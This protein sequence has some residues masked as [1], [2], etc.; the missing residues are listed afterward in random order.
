MC[1]TWGIPGP[2]PVAAGIL[3]S[4]ALTY[5]LLRQRG[6]AV[7]FSYVP[8]SMEDLE[9][10][11]D[12][13]VIVKPE[14]GSATYSVYPWGYRVFKGVAGFRRYLDEQGLAG[15]FFQYQREPHA[16]VGRFLIMEF[17]DCKWLR[18]VQ[19]AIDGSGARVFAHSTD[20]VRPETLTV[21]KVIFAERLKQ[22]EAVTAIGGEF[23]RLGFHRALMMMQF[24]EKRG[25]L[26]P[27]DFNFRPAPAFDRLAVA[28]GLQFYEK[29][30]AFLLGRADHIQLAWPA[31]C[32]GLQRMYLR[33]RKGR[34][35]AD[36]GPGAIPLITQVAYDPA[37]AYDFG[38][39]WPM[40]AAT[41]SNRPEFLRK[42]RRIVAQTRI[43]KAH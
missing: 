1:R 6:H 3:T 28:L 19:I 37:R 18:Y 23:A 33:P 16:A 24:V 30:L 15:Q 25:R 20:T 4:K 29:A 22:I 41:A 13:P 11:F 26:Y 36:F 32:V 12:R 42:A 35:E 43:R 40:F 9:L 39:A 10:R 2:D 5:E 31:P 27:I 38:Y 8:L 17:V 34:Y 7:L 14:R 21:D